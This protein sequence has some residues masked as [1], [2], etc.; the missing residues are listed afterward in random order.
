MVER[1]PELVSSQ[2]LRLCTLSHTCTHRMHLM[3]LAASRNR[4]KVVV[5]VALDAARQIFLIGI[6]QNAQ[7]VG[8]V[9][10]LQLPERTQVAQWQ[11]CCDRM[12]STLTR[13]VSRARGEL[14]WMTMPSCTGLLHEGTMRCSPS[15]STQHT[16]QAP[17]SF[18]SFR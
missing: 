7:I 1:L 14:V 11:S 5:H 18:K 10:N 8:Q 2:M 4:G 3:H 17:I 12:S 13:R 9:C 15:I 16:R 6:D